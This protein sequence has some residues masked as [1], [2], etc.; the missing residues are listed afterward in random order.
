MEVLNAVYGW[1]RLAR[2]KKVGLY[3]EVI[4]EGDVVRKDV[5]LTV[6]SD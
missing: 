1:R 4:S 3:E 2:V 6:C 5:M